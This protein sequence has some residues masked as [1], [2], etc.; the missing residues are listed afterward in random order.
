MTKSRLA[1][2]TTL[3][4]ATAML[5]L[6]A[7]AN[8][9]DRISVLPG[10]GGYN[11]A[12]GAISAPDSNGVRYIGGN[13]TRFNQLG[14]GGAMVTD[15]TSGEADRSFPK[16]VTDSGQGGQV[17]ASAPDGSGG[18]Y[19]GGDFTTVDGQTVNHAVHINSDGSLDT[20][21][22]PNL[23]GDV[24]TIA[25]SGS[26]VYLGGSF[27]TVNGEERRN[28][29]EVS[30]ADGS[31][32]SW[33]P[34]TDATVHSIA[35]SGSTVYVGG[36]FT[37]AT[38]V[39]RKGLAAIGT[40]GTL[41]S[42]TADLSNYGRADAISISGSTLYIGGS[43]TTI[44]G[45]S[46]RNA[47][48]IGTNGTVTSWNP[49][50]DSETSSLIVDGSTVYL[51][52]WFTTV[53]SNT[54]MGLAAVGTDGTLKSWDPNITDPNNWGVM[55]MAISG[56][57]LYFGGI[58]HQ[59]AGVERNDAAAVSLSDASLTSWNPDIN[60]HNGDVDTVAALGSKVLVGGEFARA[61]GIVRLHLAA[62]DA[63]GNLTDWNP[64]IQ[65][66][67]PVDS[68]YPNDWVG[69]ILVDG[70][71]VYVAGTLDGTVG[72]VERPRLAAIGTDGVVKTSF[73]PPAISSYTIS[74][75]VKLGGNLYMNGVSSLGGSARYG[76][77]AVDA[78]TG[79]AQ[80][81][82]PQTD[83]PPAVLATDG[84]NIYAGGSFTQ[85]RGPGDF[86]FTTRNKLAAFSTS[87]SLLSWNPNVYTSGYRGGVTSI[88]TS[89]STIYVG[90][91]F[92]SVK[93]QSR[94]NAA[95]LDASGNLLSWN[96]NVDGR[97]NAMS[98]FGS[99]VLLA[100]EFANVGGESHQ[101]VAAVGT[102]GTVKPWD[103]Q[104]AAGQS[105]EVA[106]TVNAGSTKVAVGGGFTSVSGNDAAGWL[107]V[108]GP[109]NPPA[110]PVLTGAPTGTYTS[111]DASVEFTSDDGATFSCSVDGG[112]YEDC[113][114]P[115]ELTGMTDGAHSLAV[116]AVNA[117][118]E[119]DPA[120]ASWTV[121]TLADTTPPEAPSVQL[122]SPATS[123]SNTT[124]A[125]ITFSGEPGGTFSCSLDGGAYQACT[126]PSTLS[127]LA[128]TAHSFSVKQT[129]AAGNVGAASTVN[130]TVDTT[131]PPAPLIT[132]G[133]AA[134]TPDPRASV[135]WTGEAG[136]TFQCKLD[137]GSWFS[138]TSPQARSDFALGSHTFSIKATDAVGNTGAVATRTWTVISAPILPPAVSTR[139]AL[140]AQ[141]RKSGSQNA[142]FVNVGQVFSAADTRPA[143]QL[144]TVQIST[145]T[146][147]A[148]LNSDP[149]PT[150]ATY[151]QGV[152][153]FASPEI[154]RPGG[155]PTWVRVGTKGG[156]WTNWVKVTLKK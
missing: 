128:G 86:N 137:A 7:P 107:F 84:T 102:N 44:A 139:V 95:A 45:E 11:G 57:T 80:A 59:V 105:W 10:F 125:S 13:F 87:G 34:G 35:L 50:P 64:G 54:R 114:S 8:A 136:A 103:P 18:Y 115:K 118:G 142:W 138:C 70:S 132:S 119:S 89:G 117:G 96:P 27:W 1:T 81:W 101:Y 147:T 32:T 69:S 20:N 75:L 14:T 62:I 123:P 127:G 106:N 67:D 51:G 48:A 143:S 52:G 55:S 40:D 120:T 28:L 71:T 141:L 39:T 113:T 30:K 110:T 76:M 43:F 152:V 46:R 17:R 77:A 135:S 97:V 88:V 42:W 36:S 98:L 63:S 4:A 100:G 21:W 154:K 85:A 112:A 94:N 91:E 5:S 140:T 99:N 124:S 111:A 109:P 26:T 151:A 134:S 148:P 33:N 156:K 93:N 129:D 153:A 133:P 38:G 12:I 72:G 92:S 16:V 144:Q 131:P 58:F 130:W 60:Y 9:I 78:S 31:L 121:S 68:N 25:V 24:F 19:L 155:Q 22:L 61:G 82:T 47:A 3:A 23:D 53:L 49:A 122:V 90:G 83:S 79:A 104:I 150:A 74:S 15:P 56:S 29:A 73:N 6:A 66:P 146:K 41:Q 145:L 149:Y 116:K 126:S 2:L 37:K 65:E 108:D